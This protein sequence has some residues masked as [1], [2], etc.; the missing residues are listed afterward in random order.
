MRRMN[1]PNFVAPN[2]YSAPVPLKVA[3]ITETYPPE[4]NGVAITIGHMVRV[5][6]KR[7]HHIQLI[8]PRQHKQDSAVQEEGY[9]EILLAGMPIPG[10]PELKVGLPAKGALLR[11]WRKQRP[12]IVHIA[13][14]GPLGWTALAAAH[15]LGLPISTDFHTN[16]HSYTKHYGIGLLQKP[17]AAYLRH[18]HN[19]SDCTMVPTA[20]LQRELEA[21]GYENVLVVSRG[22]D[23]QLFHPDK[24]SAV[25]RSAWGVTDDTPVAMLVSRLAPEKNLP[26]VIQAFE[27]M[28]SAEPR[29]KLV[30]VGDG[31]A[32]AELEKQQ[33]PNV[34][35]A[36]MRTGEDLAAHYASGDIF[37]YPSVTETY[38]NV[39]VEAMSSGLAT[40]AYDYA[41]AHKH[42]RH[43]VNGLLAPYDDTASFVAQTKALV[44]DS[45]RIKRL[46]TE[47]R[48]TVES[49]TW[50]DVAGH[51]E[52]VLIDLVRNKQG[53]SQNEST[54]YT[55]AD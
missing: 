34:I 45:A 29:C 48:M 11:L 39:T 51:L 47:A 30:I 54:L 44:S 52:A 2:E 49:P 27:Q 4:V 22:V 41:A 3:L 20:T 9:E 8:R 32:R 21:S 18:L 50:E 16:F 42:I 53:A 23:T 19:K 55:A 40:I 1:T 28:R 38:G 25:L 14:E 17:M 24:R 7:K 26:V 5:L 10:Y 33:H 12:D 36:G 13:T 6:R 43:D 31:P 46:R 37:I 35:F 15:K